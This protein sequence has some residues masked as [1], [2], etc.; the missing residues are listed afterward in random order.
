M[1]RTNNFGLT[2]TQNQDF[3]RGVESFVGSPSW[4]ALN[5]THQSQHGINAHL[6]VS[7]EVMRT[8]EDYN[9]DNYGLRVAGSFM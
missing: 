5:S 1:A 9:V 8:S 4:Q 2:Q 6:L 3:S 7:V